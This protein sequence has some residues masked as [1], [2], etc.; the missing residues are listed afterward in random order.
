MTVCVAVA[1]NN[2]LLS[3]NHIAGEELPLL[4]LLFAATPKATNVT[5][6]ALETAG[7]G[8]AGTAGTAGG[9]VCRVADDAVGALCFES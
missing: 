1:S 4:L 9:R 8:A 2:S 3:K 6:G 5:T 7:H